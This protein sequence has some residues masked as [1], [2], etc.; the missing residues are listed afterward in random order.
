MALPYLRY[1]VQSCA[2]LHNRLKPNDVVGFT[3]TLLIGN[4]YMSHKR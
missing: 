4:A 3:E 1:R 2:T